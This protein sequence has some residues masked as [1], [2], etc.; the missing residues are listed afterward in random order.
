MEPETHLAH[1]YQD[2]LNQVMNA[3][4][5]PVVQQL[6]ADAREHEALAAEEIVEQKERKWYSISAL[7]LI[8]LTLAVICF[9][10]YYY[11]HLTVPIHPAVSV[12]AFPDTDPIVA[13]ATT[14]DQVITN[15][16]ASTT[17]PVGK[18]TLVDLVT[19]TKTNTLLSDT[20]L[21]S[22]MQSA[23]PEP[24]QSTIGEARLGIVN[25]GNAIVPFII[26][27]VSN[28]QNASLQFTDAEPAL[29][30]I[31]YKPLNI[32]LAT[33]QNDES[34]PFQSQY[35]YNLPVRTLSAPASI[36]SPQTLIFLYGYA[37]NNT[38]VITTQPAVLED[39]YDAIINQN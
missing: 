5:A 32:D 21:F 34:Q 27:S 6:L 24:L 11:T 20:Q 33:Y 10:A 31:F 38:I 15:L 1:T 36:M 29:L 17:L 8:V 2:D 16:T 25:T 35:F 30:Q 4:E 26:A 14:I 13:N 28:P 23:V 3:T 12:G 37:S 22:F 7:T 19:D 18:P 39:I 9:G